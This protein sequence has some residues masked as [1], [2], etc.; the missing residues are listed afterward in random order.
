[1]NG[2]HVAVPGWDDEGPA[3]GE[4]TRFRRGAHF[5][6]DDAVRIEVDLDAIVSNARAVQ[7][8][9]GFDVAVLAM[10]KAD[11][12]GHGLASVAA[13]LHR[14]GAVAGF[15][16][17]SALDAFV[18]DEIRIDRTILCLPP[19]WDGRHH[20]VLRR[21]IV[22]VIS[23]TEDWLAF[24]HAARRSSLTARVQVKIDTGM[25]RLGIRE[26]G[27][28]ELLALAA[29]T[30]ELEI[31]GLTTHLSS[32]DEEA[33][34]VTT[35]QLD[36]FERILAR[37]HA[38]GH[39]PT[40]LHASNTAAIW[41]QPRALFRHVRT[42]I[43]LFGG[44]TPSGALL[45]PALR[46]VARIV[47]LRTVQAGEPVSYG[48]RWRAA[49]P[50]VVATLPLG[51]AHGYPRRLA[52]RAEALVHGRRCPII[53]TI[54]MEMMLVDVTDLERPLIG[55]EVVLLGDQGA[56][57]IRPT[58]V[59]DGMNG[60]VEEIFCGLSRAVPRAYVRREP[61]TLAAVPDVEERLSPEYAV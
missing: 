18:L 36:T 25:A 3:S 7:R 17:T 6:P 47:Q 59:A 56:E 20:E 58:D 1:M 42:G 4:I 30:P 60:I 55:D 16:V 27:V 15:V 39:R 52:G 40:M 13:A 11:A 50:T 22:P 19:T 24:A 49:R 48:E 44:D 21:G 57:T 54:C 23:S 5:P 46:L 14:A 10:L 61:R 26:E 51:Y 31:G 28:D 2:H 45:T 33:G 53:G 35:R 8:H 32:A 34:V 41:R 12:Y 9:V 43:A 38:A 37:F 29:R